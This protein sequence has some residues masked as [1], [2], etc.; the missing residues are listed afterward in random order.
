MGM[1]TCYHEPMATTK[2]SPKTKIQHKGRVTRVTRD[3][4]AE[5]TAKMIAALKEGKIL[6]HKPWSVEMS[7]EAPRSLATGKLYRGINTL[8]LMMAQMDLGYRSNRWGTY[9]QMAELAGMVKIQQGERERWVSPLLPNGTPDPTP[10]GV[11]KGE[12]S[13][14]IVW[15]KPIKVAAK[16]ESGNVIKDKDGNAVMRKIFPLK[17]FHVFN[18]D[19][20]EFP[21]GTKGAK[22][23]AEST[24]RQERTP[25]E[26]D[27]A[28]EA[29]LAD[30]LEHG[31]SLGHGGNSAFYRPSEDHIQMPN[32][33]DFDTTAH[34]MST[35]YH[36][37]THSTGHDSR[38]KREGIKA[39]TFGAWGDKV[40]SQEE[41][42]AEMGAAMLCA[43]A[44]IDQT[45]FDNSVAYIQ[46][47]ISKLEQDDRLILRAARE[48]QK[49]VDLVL[50]TTF[51]DDE[52]GA[53]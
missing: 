34:Y 25:A 24:A 18:M 30:Y 6:W 2:K 44:G 21:E 17:F 16:D 28:A 12:K 40:Y 50:G 19:Q 51:D 52:E 41:L 36:E 8:L 23:L 32:L 37:V 31:P 49:A 48:A 20:C 38:L 4:A 3:V 35:L 33:E 43:I 22:L 47:W 15:A 11:R 5:T 42:V 14:E 9:N 45:V 27:E 1:R 13:T 46:H 53:S 10:R 29:L 7:L 39:G 26:R